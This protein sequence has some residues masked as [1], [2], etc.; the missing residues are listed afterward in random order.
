VSQPFRFRALGACGG[1]ITATLQLQDGA[2]SLGTV[3]FIMPLGLAIIET[4]T[5]SNAAAFTVPSFGTSSLYPSTINVV[6]MGGAISKITVTINGISH[7]NPDDFD[8]LL[9]APSGQKILLMSDCGGGGDLNGVNLAFDDGAAVGLSNSQQIGSGTFKPTN[10]GDSDVL[11]SPAPPGPYSDPQQL[12]AFNGGTP[13]GAWSL[14]VYD[15]LSS[16]SGQI[17]GGW[18]L[19]LTTVAPQCCASAACATITLDPA[20]PPAGTAGATYNQTVTQSGGALP[21]TFSANGALP[22]GITLSPGGLLA[23][24]PTQTGSFP[25]SIIVTDANGC[26][27]AGMYTLTINCAAITLSPTTLPNGTVGTAYNQTFTGAPAGG[28][29]SYALTAGAL[30]PGLALNS[31]TGIVSG[32]PTQSGGFNFTITATGVGNCAGGQNYSI[33]INPS[34]TGLLFYPLL[35]PVRLMDTRANQGNCDNVSTPIAAGTSLTALAR[36]T[37][38]GITIPATAQAVVGNLTAINQSQQSGYLTIY[39]DGQPVPLASNMIYTPGQIIANN[40]TVALS[41]DG[42]FNVF[43]ERTMDV[44]IDI[45]GYYA[46]PGAGGLYYHALSKPIRMLDTRASQG[47]CDNVST[48][49]AAGTSITTLART[50]CEGLTIPATAQ[51]LVANAT[52]VN[53]SGQLGYMTIYPNGVGAPL[54]SN[55][56]YYP[57]RI[58]SNAF[59][60]S[61]S[62][63]GEFNIFAERMIDAI[64]DVAGYYSAEPTDANGPGLLFTPLARPVRILDTRPNQGNCDSVGTPIGGGTSIAA[65]AWLTCESLTLPNTARSVMGNATVINHSSQ[66]GYLTLYPEGVETPLISNMVYFPNQLL[67]NAF[68]IGVNTSNGQFRLFAER[69]LDAV[70]DVSGYFAP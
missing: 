23:G 19:T 48:P 60:V 62:S 42:K 17:A 33:S 55:I 28:G 3:N 21:V 26:V 14:Y 12:S 22:N 39:P 56:I 45:S 40:F 27:G 52:V 59:T 31:A 16:N 4:H 38:E 67:A 5:F 66:A 30:P 43:G 13:N 49:I 65:P 18:S 9:V 6:D 53:V 63:S 37:C 29:Y 15:D 57:G 70:V 54:A 34:P 2:T 24:V 32:A 58:L 46:P 68:V 36:T 61:L 69:T 10:F 35:R 7:T 44:V 8:I 47:N 50:T 64:V 1:A 11:S 41:S 51:A 20:T 25:I